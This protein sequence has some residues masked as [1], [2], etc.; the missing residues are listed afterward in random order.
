MKLTH[1]EKLVGEFALCRSCFSHPAPFPRRA[2]PKDECRRWL[3]SDRLARKLQCAWADG[4]VIAG[5]RLWRCYFPMEFA[6]GHLSHRV[7]ASHVGSLLL[8]REEARKVPT[9]PTWDVR[10]PLKHCKLSRLL[11]PRLRKSVP[12]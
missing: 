4:D 8:E 1:R 5:L 2:Q 12:E 10:S 7:R 11:H 6:K 9:R 3:E